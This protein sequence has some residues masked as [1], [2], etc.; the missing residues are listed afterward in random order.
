[1]VVRATGGS[2]SRDQVTLARAGHASQRLSA[3]GAIVSGFAGNPTQ[4]SDSFYHDHPLIHEKA[5]YALDSPSANLLGSLFLIGLAG[6]TSTSRAQ[7]AG[8]APADTPNDN[9]FDTG[10]LGL[11]GLAGLL[12][13]RR[14]DP[15]D[16]NRSDV[17]RAATSRV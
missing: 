6:V 11:V 14:R 12:G 9:G 17:N 5:Q 15:Q 2:L 3:Q 7:D 16:V 1:M 4:S 13:L 10:L 8:N